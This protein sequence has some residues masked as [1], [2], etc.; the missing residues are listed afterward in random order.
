MRTLL[1][2]EEDFA[3]TD[4]RAT[5]ATPR[6][7]APTGSTSTANPLSTSQDPLSAA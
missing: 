2:F 4:T 3:E 5:C 6:K 1:R 7:Q